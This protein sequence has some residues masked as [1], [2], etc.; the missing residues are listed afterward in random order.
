[1]ALT[2]GLLAWVSPSV[3]SLTPGALTANWKVWPL[4]QSVNFGL[5]PLQYR[6]PFQ[7]TCGIAWSTYLS[8]LNHKYVYHG[9]ANIQAGRQGARAARTTRGEAVEKTFAY[10]S[11][12]ASLDPYQWYI[13][14]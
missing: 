7:Q 4:I 1:M 5:V 10:H 13:D 11:T 12:A 9:R 8:L 6:L 3:F 2:P 14:A